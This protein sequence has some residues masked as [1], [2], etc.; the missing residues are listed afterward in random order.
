MPV[1]PAGALAQ[2]AHH[3]DGAGGLIVIKDGH[4]AAEADHLVRHADDERGHHGRIGRIAAAFQHGQAGISGLAP[5]HA[6]GAD[7]TFRMP[8]FCRHNQLLAFLSECLRRGIKQA[9]R[10]RERQQDKTRHEGFLEK[11]RERSAEY[12]RDY[13]AIWKT[14]TARR[15]TSAAGVRYIT[16]S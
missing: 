9:Q 15:A 3:F 4:F 11:G 13:I 7:F 12:C 10:T 2:T 6:D 5:A 16:D 14:V 1:S 8:I